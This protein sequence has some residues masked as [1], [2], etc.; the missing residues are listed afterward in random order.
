MAGCAGCKCLLQDC[1]GSPGCAAHLPSFALQL[2]PGPC[3]HPRYFG[4]SA[5]LSNRVCYRAFGMEPRAAKQLS[6]TVAWSWDDGSSDR[7][8]GAV[9]SVGGDELVEQRP[10]ARKCASARASAPAT[11]SV[12][13]RTDPASATAILVGCQYLARPLA[14]DVCCD[15]TPDGPRWSQLVPDGLRWPQMAGPRWPP[16]GSS[17]WPQE[18]FS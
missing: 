2:R 8:L 17:A 4:A 10:R 3:V 15:G 9:G 12:R 11:C 18:G 5:T 16:V 1:L 7:N 14:A 6:S 13:P